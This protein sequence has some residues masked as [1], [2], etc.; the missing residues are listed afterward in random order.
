VIGLPDQY[1]GQAV[2]AVYVPSFLEV[3]PASL[4]A[5]VED[6]LSKFKCPKYWVMVNHLPRNAQGKVNYEQLKTVATDSLVAC[7][8]NSNG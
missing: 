5:A 1:W 8:R 6:K 7:G 2:T 4:K 3:S